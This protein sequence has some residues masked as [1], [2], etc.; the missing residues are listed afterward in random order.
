M[1]LSSFAKSDDPKTFMV[2]FKQKE[3]K[4]LKTSIQKI[5]DQFSDAF[6][7]KT[8]SGNSDLTLV[9]EV[10]SS[11]IDEC[12]LGS[13]IVEIGEGQEMQLQEIA[14]RLFDLTEGKEELQSF[15][16]EYEEAQQLKKNGKLAKADTK[17]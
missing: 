10:P 3:L 16:S 7:T 11:E 14:F 13:F 12:S 5:E 2:I 8:Y 15:I 17:L 6:K 9:I 4:S 1:S